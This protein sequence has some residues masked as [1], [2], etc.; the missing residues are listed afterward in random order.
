MTKD[1]A[2]YLSLPYTTVLIEGDEDEGG[3]FAE[4]KELPGCMTYDDTKEETLEMLEE[5]KTLW[6]EHRIEKGYPIPEPATS[7]H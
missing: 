5:A 7:P 1:L 2:Y 6:L 4:I 3:W